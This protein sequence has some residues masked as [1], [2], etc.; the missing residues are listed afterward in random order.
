MIGSCEDYR[1][2]QDRF[3]CVECLD[4]FRVVYPAKWMLQVHQLTHG[5]MAWRVVGED[6]D[7]VEWDNF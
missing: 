7:S 1:P 6:S 4:R 5:H 3:E 2:V